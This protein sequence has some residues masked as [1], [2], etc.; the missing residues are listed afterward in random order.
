MDE[1]GYHTVELPPQLSTQDGVY[2]RPDTG[3]SMQCGDSKEKNCIDPK[4]LQLLV[5]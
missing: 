2:Y 3:T 4:L 5:G 1:F